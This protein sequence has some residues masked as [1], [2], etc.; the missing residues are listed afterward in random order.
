MKHVALALCLLVASLTSFAQAPK[1]TK[2]FKAFIREMKIASTADSLHSQMKSVFMDEEPAP[3][4]AFF[5]ELKSRVS[6]K[7]LTKAIAPVITKHFSDAELGDIAAKMAAKTIKSDDFDRKPGF[8]TELA[9]AIA[10]W[11]A[12]AVDQM[13]E[14]LEKEQEEE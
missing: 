12:T 10:S 9:T 6:E 14:K 3:G 13:E 8:M 7:E 1:Q 11:A 2:N 5:K 4:K